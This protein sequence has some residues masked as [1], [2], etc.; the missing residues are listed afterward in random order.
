MRRSSAYRVLRGR[1]S[2]SEGKAKL[3]GE[4]V[5]QSGGSMKRR[6]GA[7]PAAPKGAGAPS[8]GEGEAQR[9]L[10]VGVNLPLEELLHPV[11]P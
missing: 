11:H 3:S 4:F 6:S 10:G 5:K 7:R 1:C 8:E 2:P 9:S